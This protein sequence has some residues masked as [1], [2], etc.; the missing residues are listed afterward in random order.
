MGISSGVMM[1][2]YPRGNR[3]H[4]ETQITVTPARARDEFRRLFAPYTQGNASTSRSV[5]LNGNMPQR[6]AGTSHPRSP[7]KRKSV[8]EISI[9][10]FCL[11]ITTQHDVPNNDEKQQ[12]LVGG[13]GEKKVTLQ[14][15]ST[16]SD[17]VSALKETPKVGR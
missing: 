6:R 11:A 8:K 5:S 9:K 13:L 14:A 7:K 15:D 12:L 16:S 1:D 3:F 2:F 10:F 4:W 17:V